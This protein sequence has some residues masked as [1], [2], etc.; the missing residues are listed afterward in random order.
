MGSRTRQR[1]VV[2]ALPA[3]IGPSTIQ[4]VAVSQRIGPDL[5]REI[6][7][8][9]LRLHLD[10][11]TAP[12]FDFGAVDRF[13]PVGPESYDDVRRMLAACEAAGFMHLR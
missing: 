9:L 13:T 6:R 8:V 12:L 1:L 10:P 3:A 2:L 4:P 11:V 5:R 7:N